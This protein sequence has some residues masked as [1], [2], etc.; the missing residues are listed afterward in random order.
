MENPG[1]FF[2]G[3]FKESESAS[4]PKIRRIASP[5]IYAI[6]ITPSLN[7][8]AFKVQ[9]RFEHYKKKHKYIL[10]ILT[11]KINDFTVKNKTSSNAE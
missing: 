8:N 2:N 1:F 11:I 4:D 3:F 5:S 6:K 10:N 9:I 7:Q